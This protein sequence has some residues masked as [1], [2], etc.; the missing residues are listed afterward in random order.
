[1]EVF[2]YWRH[3][4]RPGIHSI[5]PQTCVTRAFHSGCSDRDLQVSGQ[6]K[7]M[8]EVKKYH[9]G[10]WKSI[11]VTPHVVGVTNRHRRER[12]ST[13][14]PPAFRH[15]RSWPADVLRRRQACIP[16]RKSRCVSRDDVSAGQ[17]HGKLE[18]NRFRRSATSMRD[19]V[20]CLASNW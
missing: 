7:S 1:M 19:C 12:S 8:I 16:S 14:T 18:E 20:L 15:G 6:G 2:E 4:D 9:R 17:W 3:R 11:R 13:S 10:I 5:S